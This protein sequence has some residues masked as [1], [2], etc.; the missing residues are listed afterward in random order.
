MKRRNEIVIDADRETVW[1]SFCNPGNRSRWQPTLKSV[2]HRSGTPGEPGQVAELVYVENGREV[3]MTE[4]LTEKRRPDFM[5]GTYET[6]HGH[7]TVVNH[8]EAIGATQTRW[9]VYFYHRFK[10]IMRLMGPLFRKSVNARTEDR[11]QRFRRL[12][13]TGPAGRS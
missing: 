7:A 5:A 9:T 12:V 6:A 4:T 11:M 1:Q 2:T 8:F 13:E 10:G 3:V